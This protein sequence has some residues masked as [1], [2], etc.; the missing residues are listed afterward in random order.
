VGLSLKVIVSRAGK[1]PNGNFKVLGLGRLLESLD[2]TVFRLS[3]DRIHGVLTVGILNSRAGAIS[4][5]LRWN[6]C[7]VGIG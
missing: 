3:V 5:N 4:W 1:R 6:M 2:Y 7:G